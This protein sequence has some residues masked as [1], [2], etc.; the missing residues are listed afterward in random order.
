MWVLWT[1]QHYYWNRQSLYNVQDIMKLGTREYST[2]FDQN[3]DLLRWEERHLLDHL[4]ADYDKIHELHRKTTSYDDHKLGYGQIID[5]DIELANIDYETTGNMGKSSTA[6]QGIY[7]DSDGIEDIE[8]VREGLTFDDAHIQYRRQSDG[9]NI[10]NEYGDSEKATNLKTVSIED[11]QRSS[12]GSILSEKLRWPFRGAQ[13]VKIYFIHVGKCAG[14]SLYRHLFV[15]QSRQRLGCRMFNVPKNTSDE[16]CFEKRGR[17]RTYGPALSK[18]LYGH[19]HMANP[20]Y[21]DEERQWLRNN[22]NLLLFTVRDPGK[23]LTKAL[24]TASRGS[25]AN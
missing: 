2:S 23:T 15:H 13:D 10:E 12:E 7:Q 21:S 1:S 4:V 20:R 18:R 5:R 6:Q 3:N 24:T 9:Q 17:R 16:K 25:H 22:T 11:G 14:R 19:F 8:G